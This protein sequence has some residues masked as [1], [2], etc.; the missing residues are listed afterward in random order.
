M[1]EKEFVA[2]VDQLEGYARENPGA[3]KLRVAM[4]AALGYVFLIGT[5]LV[6]LLLVL[7][8]IYFGGVNWL[9]IKIL[10]IPLGVAAIVL[11]SLWVEF[12]EPEG[13]E[14]R[15]EDAPRLF[16][17]AK[18]TREAT[19][20]P[21]LHKVLLTDEFNAGIVQRPLLGVFGWQE[22]YLLV[23]L[24]LLRGLSPDEVRAVIAHEFGHLSGK[25]SAFSG[26]IYRVRQTWDQVLDR[27]RQE[28]RFGSG[29][30]ESFFNWYAPYFAAYSFVLARSREYEA[31]RTSV[32]LCGK[33]NAAAA[34]V[35]V[36][37]RDKSLSEEFWPTFF[38]R[39]SM[40][41]EPPKDT[42]HEMLSALR[43]P[44]LPDKAKMWFTQA[45]TQKHGYSDTHPA[46][47][48]R[49]EAIGYP[50]VRTSADLEAFLKVEDQFGDEYFLQS[51]PADFIASKN[52]LWREGV[53]E[54][55]SERF[56]FVVEAEKTLAALEEK[57]R[58]EEL[59]QEDRWERA[60]LLR[61][62]KGPEA[63]LPLLK[64]IVAVEPDHAGANYN[65]GEALLEQGDEA[66]IRN[67]EVAMEKEVHAIPAGCE[68][69][70][71]FL[72]SRK[73]GEEAERYRR[74]IT[75]YFKEME[76]ARTE[77]TS[78]GTKDGFK[79]HEL[80]P[81]VIR[82]LCEQLKTYEDLATAYL[83]QKVVQYFPQ[84]PGYVL[85][86]TR[87]KAWYSGSN[88]AR[89]VKLV[90]QLAEL[91]TFPGFTYVIALE[92]AYKPL[93]KVFERIEGAEI[94]RA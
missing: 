24:P 60:R 79:Q 57:A 45:L 89:D 86:V 90:E 82:E 16:D 1:E 71:N 37:L 27:M 83:V 3:Y 72:T 35:K 6:V 70:Y 52:R 38:K 12:P 78:I 92:D 33:E 87:K 53:V 4:L 62:T 5:V 93:R 66:G 64:E 23:G 32:L 28:Q 85:G 84:E 13:L 61:G 47:G 76:F 48:D 31:D 74:C 34:L 50:D 75:D 29:I 7:T 44:L 26:W 81:E 94:Y 10:L 42:F 9:I 63:A 43:Q 14:L 73:R 58:T 65:L 69:I 25:H 80:A 30:F 54:T 51:V 17:L 18:T 49:L 68:L 67:I 40:E 39:A 22:N 8:V 55:W 20:G 19:Q 88:N 21:R 56:K 77:R 15:Y 2:L 41:A 11:R 91:L 59:T 36:E 46:L